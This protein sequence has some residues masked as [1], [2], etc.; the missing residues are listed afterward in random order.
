MNQ[1]VAVA[2][3]RHIVELEK[4]VAAQRTL[5]ER[6]VAANRDT[7]QASRTLRVLQDALLLTKEHLGLLVRDEAKTR[8]SPGP[9][10]EQPAV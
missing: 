9:T 7:S 8:P 2:A 4:R 5:I 1:S 3:R 10:A 6:L